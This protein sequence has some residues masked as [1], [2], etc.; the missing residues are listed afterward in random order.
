MLRLFC[1]FLGLFSL[2]A[3][4]QS[5]TDCGLDLPPVGAAGGHV[6]VQIYYGDGL[7]WGHL[8]AV[9]GG[10]QADCTDINIKAAEFR[11]ARFVWV[12][13]IEPDP[14]GQRPRVSIGQR[15][16]PSGSIKNADFDGDGQ[17]TFKDY[18]YI[19]RE[20]NANCTIRACTTDLNGDMSVNA[21]DVGEFARVFRLVHSPRYQNQT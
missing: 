4:A 8:K 10:Y 12:M 21:L 14:T 9:P 7:R 20:Y 16:T 6:S 13:L 19:V 11:R 3:L 15:L 18:V 1:V 17:I 2:P 5:A